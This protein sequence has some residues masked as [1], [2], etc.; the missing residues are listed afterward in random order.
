MYV[1][2][3]KHNALLVLIA[4]YENA[5]R[6]LRR[7][8]FIHFGKTDQLVGAERLLDSGFDTLRDVVKDNFFK[9]KE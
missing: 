4:T 5:V 1:F 9:G 8:I 7:E 6:E 2:T 3:G